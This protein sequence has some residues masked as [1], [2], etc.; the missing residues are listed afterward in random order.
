MFFFAPFQ[1]KDIF[2]ILPTLS[3]EI[4]RCQDPD[5]QKVHGYTLSLKW[6]DLGIS[7]VWLFEH[8]DLV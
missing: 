3:L 5:C 7:A 1:D 6:L 4:M 8:D 2:A